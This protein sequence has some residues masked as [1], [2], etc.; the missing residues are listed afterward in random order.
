MGALGTLC[1]ED[2]DN[3]AGGA[4]RT[5][6]A[7]SAELGVHHVGAHLA[8]RT[9]HPLLDLVEIGVGHLGPF[10][11]RNRVESGCSSGYV[12]ADG[13]MVDAAQGGG[14][15]IGAGEVIGLVYLHAFLL[16]QHVVGPSSGRWSVRHC[17]VP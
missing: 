5:H 9:L 15:S 11:I 8:R 7:E 10:E 2:G 13:V 4:F 16:G 3:A 6:V 14:G 17:H 1:F 12:A